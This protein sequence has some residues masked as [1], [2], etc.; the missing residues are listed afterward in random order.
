MANEDFWSQFEET[1]KQISKISA[2]KDFWSQFESN[3]QQ[4]QVQQQNLNK[5]LPNDLEN[6]GKNFQQGMKSS[7]SEIPGGAKEGFLESLNALRGKSSR[8][9]PESEDAYKQSGKSI[10]R[11]AGSLP[12]M[13]AIAA[14]IAM[15]GGAAGFP[16]LGSILGAGAAG[17]ATTPGDVP[18]RAK[19]ALMNAAPFAAGKIAHTIAKEMPSN[20]IETIFTKKDP[21]KMIGAVQKGHDIL[22]KEASTLYKTVGE[23]VNKRG[24]NNVS[25]QPSVIDDA[26]EFFPKSKANKDLIEKARMG[27]YEAIRKLQSDLGKRGREHLESKYGADRDRGEL[28][29]DARKNIN[30]LTAKHFE[31]LGHSDLSQMLTKANEKYRT[32]KDTYYSIPAIAK[33]VSHKTR[34]IPKNPLNVFSEQSNQ[35]EKLNMAHP[36]IQEQVNLAKSKEILGNL[37]KKTGYSALGTYGID[38]Y[39]LDHK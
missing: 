26:A 5:F 20:L 8:A 21:E 3:E 4:P 1:P 11:I 37:L 28:M 19:S 24:I 39:L 34:K 32:L 33:M 7:F 27:D 10:G 15:T 30:D 13:G 23:E 36:E 17:Y 31:D 18:T 6:R 22:D 16:I 12:V 14:P 25:I 29:L 9:S 35:M 2:P 38:K